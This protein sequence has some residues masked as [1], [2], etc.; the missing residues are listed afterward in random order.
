MDITIIGAGYVGLVSAVLF[1][2]AGH[3]VYCIENNPNKLRELTCGHCYFYEDGFYEC[4]SKA[5]SS[6]KLSFH[7]DMKTS[8]SKSKVV[9]LCLP[10]PS[11][12]GKIADLSALYQVAVELSKSIQ[13]NTVIVLKSTVPVGSTRRI[14]EIISSSLKED[15]NFEIQMNP[16]FLRQ[17]DAVY[18]FIHPFLVVV[19]REEQSENNILYNLYESV[20]E[21]GT[22]YFFTS[23]ENAEMIKYASNLFLANR[24]SLVNELAYLCEK[25][26]A[27]IRQIRNAIIKDPNIGSGYLNAGIGYGG[28]C[29][30]KDI[31]ALINLGNM[32]GM[33]L[34]LIQ[35][36][37]DVNDRQKHSLVQK[38]LCEFSG[39]LVGK[40][41]AIWG[42]TFKPNTSDIREAPSIDIIND[43]KY[44]GGT[45]YAY[46]PMNEIIQANNND[47]FDVV[48]C[49]NKYSV[50]DSADALLVLTEWE[51][52]FNVDFDEIYKRM[53]KPLVLD[54]RDVISID[55]C[56]RAEIRVI[57]VGRKN[58]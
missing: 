9:F 42:L 55:E 23:F 36:V 2:N 32:Y 49:D 7:S 53:K 19:G 16:E 41:I 6:G 45:I 1:A 29:F 43:I 51:E 27:D 24:I 47:I 10:T 3:R 50:L 54:G 39:S 22:E 18:D 35:A 58:D 30:P 11:M 4:F 48:F 15:I 52:F 21:S 56:N 57:K 25:T 37:K 20:V 28:S 5:F 34:P 14:K 31:D 13:N 17:G 8:V 40:R 46:D 12:K 44:L 26:G 33:T 38:L